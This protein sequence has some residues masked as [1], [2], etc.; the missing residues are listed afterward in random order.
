MNNIEEEIKSW[1]ELLD[2]GEIDKIIY[3]EEINKLKIKEAKRKEHKNF[4]SHELMKFGSQILI[5][6]IVVLAIIWIFKN[7]YVTRTT[8]NVRSLSNIQDPIQIPTKGK[9]FKIIDNSNFEINF[10]AT[11]KISGRVVDVQN[12]FGYNAQNKL[13]PRDIG[14]SWGSLANEENNKKIKWTS[15]GNRYLSWYSSD[16]RWVNQ[17][18]GQNKISEH[19]SNNH[20]IPSDK[21]VKKLINSIKVGDYVRIEGYLVNVFSKNSKG[22]YFEWKSSTSRTDTGDGACEVIYV[23]N[24]IWLK[25]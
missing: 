18:G 5:V 14:L 3:D 19:V 2:A 21:K 8:E 1:K 7:N 4:G 10:V 17:M 24:V 20:L 9:A 16:G 15:L 12:Y 13:S 23:T 25:E 6:I 11:Y 22:A